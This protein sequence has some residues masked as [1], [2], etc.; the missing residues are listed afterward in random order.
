MIKKFYTKLYN[1]IKSNPIEAIFIGLISIILIHSLLVGTILGK[2]DNGDFGRFYLY[3]GLLIKE[4][5]TKKFT[6]DIFIKFN[7]R[8]PG[9]LLPFGPNWVS[10][11]LLL[12]LAVILNLLI[13]AVTGR[14]F[15]DLLSFDIRYL[16]ILYIGILSF[17]LPNYKSFK[18]WPVVQILCGIFAIIFSQ[19]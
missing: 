2:A 6:T 3:G 16:A 7:I 12:K 18:K 9:L 1:K 19:M 11:T 10:G 13:K 17:L 4:A 15:I 5:P 8:H 14:I